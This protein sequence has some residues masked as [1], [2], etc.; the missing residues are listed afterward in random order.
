M[1]GEKAEKSNSTCQRIS[2]KKCKIWELEENWKFLTCLVHCSIPDA[3]NI[4]E[5]F[6]KQMNVWINHPHSTSILK[7]SSAYE[8]PGDV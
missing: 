8:P 1:V 6:V 7:V 3:M 2:F 5:I 4:Q